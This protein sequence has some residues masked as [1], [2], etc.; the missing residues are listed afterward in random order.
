MRKENKVVLVTGASAGIGKATA[1]V[2]GQKGWTVYAAARRVDAMQELLS[3]GI[4][5]LQLDIT[6]V[7]QCQA[8]VEQILSSEGRIDALVNNAGYG[9]YGPL[10]KVSDE[11]ARRQFDVNIFGLMQ[12]T[13][14]VLP[15]M[16]DQRSGKII[17]ISSVGGRITTPLG[18]WYHATKFA[19]EGLSDS[20][21]TEVKPFG[22]DVVVIQPGNITSEW[23]EVAAENL[24]NTADGG[25]YRRLEE[26]M[27]RSFQ[28]GVKEAK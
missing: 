26:A 15:Q 25:P 6:D 10:E 16:R 13:R 12:L 19:L 8:A 23:A 18:G 20:L 2:L 5:L 22:I 24:Q 3:G 21:R 14:L 28:V 1:R 4:K 17:N 27:T 7:Q 11:E 9:S